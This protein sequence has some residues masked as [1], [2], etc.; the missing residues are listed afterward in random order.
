MGTIRNIAFVIIASTVLACVLARIAI[1]G[2]VPMFQ[3]ETQSYLEGREYQQAP[4]L[5]V[6]RLSNGTF[7]SEF[8]HFTSDSVPYRNNAILADATLER[9]IIELG[10]V[11]FGYEAYP[12]FFNSRYVFCPSWGSITEYP[13]TQK[14]LTQKALNDAAGVFSSLMTNNP[15]IRWRMAIVDRSRNSLASP[16]RQ[17]VAQPADYPFVMREFAELLP[18][19]C[20]VFDLSFSDT[21]AYY[22]AYFKTDHHWQVEGALQAYRRV[23]ES[24]GKSPIDDVT[25][26]T[27]YEGPFYGS[28]ARSGLITD[29]SDSVE[30]VAYEQ[31]A[32]KVK[33]NG[34][35]KEPSFL[36]GYSKWGDAY[37]KRNEFDNVYAHYFHGDP[38]IM[39]ITNQQL[40]DASSLLII[41]DSFSNNVERFFAENYQ[42]VYVIDPRHYESSLQQFLNERKI[43]DAVFIMGSNTIVA[44]SV[45]DCL[46][47]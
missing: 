17:Y 13:D 26:V 20:T 27:G 38:G 22:D 34:K 24:F 18:D 19:A 45:L 41:A 33:A 37:E 1:G 6:K 2:I 5:T 16:A 39:E 47:G 46:Q 10:N 14:T 28:E 21:A 7:Q 3:P 29:N 44:T 15:D 35:K 31:S 40:E 9:A 12:T 4:R 30:D 42:T 36:G 8:E 43:D 23:V 25:L 11:P 32:L